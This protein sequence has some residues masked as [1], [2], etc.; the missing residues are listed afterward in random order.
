M[1]SV[2]RQAKTVDEAVNEALEILSIDSSDM[3]SV[4]VEVLE[5]PKAG[6]FGIFGAKDAVVKVSVKDDL[7]AEL[8][9]EVFNDDDNQEE[10][11]KVIEEKVVEK[12]ENFTKDDK[13]FEK[14]QDDV[15]EIDQRVEKTETSE[16]KEIEK[17][18]EVQSENI[19][20]AVEEV[21]VADE[22]KPHTKAE[23]S[24]ELSEKSSEKDLVKESK[25]I[26]ESE[27]ISPVLLKD[28]LKGMKIEGDVDYSVEDNMVNI[29][30]INTNQR[31]TSIIIGKRGDTLDS[32]QYI[33]N[34]AENRE[35]DFY[36]RVNLDISNYREKRKESL[37]KLAN[38][39]S[40]KA[41]SQNRNIRLEPM[42]AYERKIIHSVL[43]D[44]KDIETYSEGKEPRRRLVIKVK[45]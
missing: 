34:L 42:N 16:D 8:I 15:V 30:I 19:T 29:R 2:I 12:D 24:E 10:V 9:N 43:Q 11:S 25:K 4:N 5:E 21:E 7:I 18:E 22:E 6:I 28:I 26:S 36:I 3:D 35:S 38:N 14:V 23:A 45:N 31:D 17:V 13:N 40:K 33:L 39:M 20:E 32:I 37:I 1:R 44:V 41:I 27:L